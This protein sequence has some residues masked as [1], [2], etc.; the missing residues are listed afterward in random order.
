M[1]RIPPTGLII[2]RKCSELERPA[3]ALPLSQTQT[4]FLCT[5]SLSIRQVLQGSTGLSIRRVLQGPTCLNIRRLVLHGCNARK[6]GYGEED[7]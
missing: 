1:P 4:T 7:R 5:T 2:T 3:L 6:Q